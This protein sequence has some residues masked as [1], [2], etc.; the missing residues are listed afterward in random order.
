LVWCLLASVAV[1]DGAFAQQGRGMARSQRH[2]QAYI[3]VLRDGATMPDVVADY[4]GQVSARRRYHHVFSGFGARMSGATAAALASDPRVEAVE[5][6]GM[7]QRNAA[8]GWPTWGLDRIDQPRPALDQTYAFHNQ[9]KGVAVYVVDGG[10]YGAHRDFGDR[11]VGGFD[12]TGLG[13]RR[14]CDGHGSHVAG[15]VG[16]RRFGVAKQVRIIPVRVVGCSPTIRRSDVLAGLDFIV[17]HHRKG[18]PAVANISLGGSASSVMDRAV[19]R[20]ID[21]GVTVVA[22]AG[23]GGYD[24]CSMS[25]ARVPRV[26]AVSAV[27]RH[28]WSPNWAN[29]GWCVDLF[30]PGVDIK[31]VGL[32]T[33]T[34]IKTMSGTSM[35]APHVAGAAARYLGAHP[36]AGPRTVANHLAQT[37]TRTARNTGP[38]TTRML[39][40]PGKVP[41]TVGNGLSRDWVDPDDTVRVRTRLRNAVTGAGLSRR[42]RLQARRPGTTTWST[43][44]S[45]TTDGAGRASVLHQPGTAMEY[46]WRHAGTLRTRPARSAITKVEFR[47][48]V[49]VLGWLGGEEMRGLFST[50]ELRPLPGYRIVLDHRPDM[51][52][53]P[54]AVA[55][56]AKT[57]PDG[58]VDFS[59]Y[60]APGLEYRMRH[61]GTEETERAKSGIYPN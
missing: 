22:A 41:T 55:G 14:D 52:G 28:D 34:A 39:Y 5:A 46:R 57:D 26:I 49:T 6:D 45:R 15:T 54:W 8:Q 13:A 59:P 9:G 43:I 37:A 31:S 20:V 58:F 12:V 36:K 32:A 60:R 2:G 1:A 56:E 24:A 30:A 7:M 40:V 35:A 18:R 23:N 4:R 19:N 44:A 53:S 61:E 50:R 10:V 21:D 33:R 3:V 27:N 47:R 29:V 25:P 17:R 42:V 11:V 16:G 48:W 38:S 51:A